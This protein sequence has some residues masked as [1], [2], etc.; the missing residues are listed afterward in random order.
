[1]G[2]NTALA[3]QGNLDLNFIQRNIRDISKTLEVSHTEEIEELYLMAYNNLKAHLAQGTLAEDPSLSVAA[4]EMINKVHFQNK[5]SGRK[6]VDTL[7][8]ARVLADMPRARDVTI[9]EEELPDTE[10]AEASVNE[11]G[12]FG[13]VAKGDPN[14]AI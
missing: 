6:I 3:V 2:D 8:K 12:V 9:E 7:I 5:D 14:L 11:G 1:M 4:F 13:K 10:A